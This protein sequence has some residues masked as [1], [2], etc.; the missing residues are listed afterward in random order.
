MTIQ[1]NVVEVYNKLNS[2]F[3]DVDY[4]KFMNHGYYPPFELVKDE[5]QVNQA[6]LYACLLNEINTDNLKIL[7]VGCGRGGGVNIYSKYY[8]FSEVHGCDINQIGINHCKATIENVQF[9]VSDAENLEYEDEYFD[10]VT[11]VESSHCYKDI[12][13]FHREVFRVLKPNGY[14]LYTDIE[15]KLGSINNYFN[16]KKREDITNNVFLASKDDLNRLKQLP[17][18]KQKYWLLNLAERC[19]NDYQDRTNVYKT[20]TFIKK[21]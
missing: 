9:K 4:V 1:S 17:E 5:Q 12:D 11:N 21:E 8:Q 10:I 18:T 13:K 7:D 2:F 19:Y 14:F 20:F 16:T 6:S 3:N 15:P